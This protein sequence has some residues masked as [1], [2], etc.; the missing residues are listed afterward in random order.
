MPLLK[1]KNVTDDA[2]QNIASEGSAIDPWSGFNRTMF[3]FNEVLDEN[4]LLP[5]TKGYRAVVP[6]PVE[7]GVHNFFW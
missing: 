5:V 4:I 6:D 7:T 2:D 1:K 3:S